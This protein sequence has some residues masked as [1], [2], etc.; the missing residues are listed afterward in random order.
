MRGHLTKKADVFSF[1]V[2]ALEI[3]SGRPNF[4]SS[5]EGEKVFLLEWAWQLHE[6]NSILR[7]VDP[8]P[9]TGTSFNEKEVKRLVGISLLCTQSS[10]LLRPPMSR[11]VAMLSGDMEVSTVTSK[12][13]YL[14]DWK[15]DDLGSFMTG[16]A[17]KGSGT[18]QYKSSTS[19]S[20]IST[21][22]QAPEVANQAHPTSH[23]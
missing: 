11:V 17:T 9:S 8:R 22:N 20:T 12:L 16:L 2:L 15:F 19:T 5:L 21:T 13:G 14:I 4:D 1:S 3:V 6:S 23:S 7:L 18:S 10:P